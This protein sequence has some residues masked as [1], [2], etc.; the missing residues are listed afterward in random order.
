MRRRQSKSLLSHALTVMLLPLVLT[1]VGYA[2]FSQS[3]SVTGNTAK[4]AYSYSQSLLMTY[5][6]TTTPQSG[7]T[8]YSQNVTIKNNGSNGVTSWQV[9]FD[10]PAGTSN[11]SCSAAVTCSLLGTTVTVDSTAASDVIDPAGTAT[12]IVSFLSSPTD[13]TLQNVI[14]SGVPAPV[15]QPIA[16]LTVTQKAGKRTKVGRVFQWPYTFTVTNNSGQAVS[17]W[18]ITAN[19]SSTTNSVVLMASTVNYTTSATQITITSKTP[20]ANGSNFQFAGTLGSTT[21]N[22]VL[23]GVTIQGVL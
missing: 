23:S 12:F 2:V 6:K 5:T 17:A 13:Y 21:A 15:Y 1:S 20:V 3:L 8:L 14:V 18:R 10:V 16:G 4:P 11:L 7:S 9:K 19:W 22:W